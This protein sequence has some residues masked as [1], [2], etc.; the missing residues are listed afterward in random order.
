MYLDALYMH[1]PIIIIVCS[2]CS[3]PLLWT[4]VFLVLQS[5]ICYCVFFADKKGKFIAIKN[6]YVNN[7]TLL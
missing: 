1:V 5:L 7:C 4:K 6:R 3:L 2:H